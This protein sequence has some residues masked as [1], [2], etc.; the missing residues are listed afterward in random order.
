MSNTFIVFTQ[1]ADSAVAPAMVRFLYRYA[2]QMTF[3]EF[4]AAVECIPL[5]IHMD[6]DRIMEK[7]K[8]NLA[9]TPNW[10]RIL[11]NINDAVDTDPRLYVRALTFE[12]ACERNSVLTL[13]RWLAR[14]GITA[15]TVNNLPADY[16]TTIIHHDADK[17]LEWAFTHGGDSATLDWCAHVLHLARSIPA[18]ERDPDRIEFIMRSNKIVLLG[19]T[20]G[21]LRITS[22]YTGNMRVA[23]EYDDL[24]IVEC[25]TDGCELMD[26]LT[27]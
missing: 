6:K 13:T 8:N 15:P 11:Y 27:S 21:K 22:K 12:L 10:A 25:T 16:L 19:C 14:R 26:L 18:D 17:I 7:A 5:D 1:I 9:V 20:L 24:V 23:V 3:A 2:D 4:K